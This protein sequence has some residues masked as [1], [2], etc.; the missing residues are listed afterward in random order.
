MQISRGDWYILQTI[1]IIYH[2]DLV[3]HNCLEVVLRPFGLFRLSTWSTE[4]QFQMVIQ[5]VRSWCL[6]W[7]KVDLRWLE[8]L[9]LVIYWYTHVTMARFKSFHSSFIAST[10]V[11]KHWYTSINYS[12]DKLCSGSPTIAWESTTFSLHPKTLCLP[13]V[14]P[15]QIN[16]CAP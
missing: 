7:P 4:I 14:C 16:F 1:G 10:A 3:Q 8:R 2:M 13:Y 11:V 12:T 5:L 9:L 15:M 6:R